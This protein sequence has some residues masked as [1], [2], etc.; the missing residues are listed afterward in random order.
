[1]FQGLPA[2]KDQNSTVFGYFTQLIYLCPFRH[3]NKMCNVLQEAKE[4][5]LIVNRE[6]GDTAR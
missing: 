2:I 5:V 1:H 6:F 4:K 3:F